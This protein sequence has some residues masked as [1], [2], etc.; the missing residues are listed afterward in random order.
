MKKRFILII[1]FLVIG[2]SL[3][4]GIILQ[5]GIDEIWRT[6]R[7]FS[8]LK[9]LIFFAVS[10]L[11]FALYTLRWDIILKS[12]HGKDHNI[13]FTRLYLHRMS[14]FALSYL[15]PSAQT[16]GEPL[17]IMLLEQ[18]GIPAKTS[19]SSVI[20]DKA[21]EY[22]ALF[23]FISLGIL[24]ALFDGTL[25][26]ESRPY[27]ITVLVILVSVTGWFYYSSVNDIGFFSSILRFFH[28]T[29]ISRVHGFEQKIV[30]V[31]RQMSDFYREDTKRFLKLFLISLVITAFLLLEHFMVARFMG[32]TMT[33]FQTFLVSTI[34][35][36]AYVIPVPGGLGLLEGGHAAMFAALGIT[37]NAFALVFI[38]RIRDLIFVAAGLVHASTQSLNLL[39]RSYKDEKVVRE[40]EE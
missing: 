35:Y 3:F 32:V 12:V 23:I 38:I 13:P 24:F 21:L 16:G 10:V 33:F 5:T 15:T 20:I 19:T 22:S 39:K 18:E 11:N 6:L 14:G 36:I 37:I 2:I 25:P 34:P 17:R 26:Q 31:E 4:V 28:F 7:T 29:R 8:L 40:I 27:L 9:F 1:V 30:K